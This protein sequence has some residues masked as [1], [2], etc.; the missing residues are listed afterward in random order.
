MTT[1]NPVIPTTGLKATVAAIA[2]QI[3]NPNTFR[4]VSVK[5]KASDEVSY[6]WRAVAKEVSPKEA[7]KR[8]ITKVFTKNLT[9]ATI[10]NLDKTVKAIVKATKANIRAEKKLAKMRKAEPVVT[11]VADE[12]PLFD[13][14]E[15]HYMGM[16][17]CTEHQTCHHNW[18]INTPA[19]GSTT[20]KGICE[21][22]G[23]VKQFFNSIH[24]QIM[25][26]RAEAKGI[27]AE[28]EEE[29]DSEEMMELAMADALNAMVDAGL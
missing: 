9:S 29:T 12:I 6:V 16:G 3:R 5:P 18:A 14:T 19:K 2:E 7:L 4:L 8:D 15:T 20:S 23:E 21:H 26:K 28:F 11:I 24:S 25:A 1:M 27:L 13:I 17:L 22:C 10:A